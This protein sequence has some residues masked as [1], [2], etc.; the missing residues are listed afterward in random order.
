V[1]LQV[2]GGLR[3]N[4]E[5]CVLCHNPMNTDASTRA[6][7]AAPYKTQPAQGINLNLLVHRI[8][9]GINMQASNRTYAVI[10]HGGTPVD[11]SSTLFPAMSAT[12]SATDAR[13]CSLCHVNS[14][15]QND[16][17]LTGLLPVTDPQGPL[18]PVQPFT[19]A[20]TGCHVD[21]PS[22]SHA[23]SNTTVLG[24]A[25]RSALAYLSD[26]FGPE[27][28]GLPLPLT[29]EVGPRERQF[30][31][32]ILERKIQTI[33]TSSCG[34]LFDAVA[35]ILGVRH[36]TTY[37]GQAAI[38]LEA[39]ASSASGS[40]PFALTGDTPCQVDL[41]PCIEAI[42][43]EHQSGASVA[44]ISARF[45]RTMACVVL[46]ACLRIR[47]SDGLNRVC[48][49]GGTFQNL[50]LLRHTVDQLRAQRF[51]VF[52][53]R[54]V[55]TNDAGLSLGQALVANAISR[56]WRSQRMNCALRAGYRVIRRS[57]FGESDN[58][59]QRRA[60]RGSCS[61]GIRP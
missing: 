42:A 10:G 24:E 36:Q 41:R 34:R 60:A 44:D 9:Y 54:R 7:A 59:V 56:S 27:A 50:R 53:H 61:L 17:T 31:E 22:A 8:H 48:L 3:N 40:Y 21:L 39:A 23:L 12:G 6:T 14:S 25:W 32:K 4:T 35:S 18:N 28:A 46:D 16:L 2:H 43:R 38:E 30:V 26:T 51:E 11:F 57:Q 5:Y 20:C 37:E 49:S 29:R 47:E 55:P 1:N 45:H 52:V 58:R 19:S 33:E 13:N 15:E